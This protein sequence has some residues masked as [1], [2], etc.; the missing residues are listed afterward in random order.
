[1]SVIMHLRGQG[2]D[3]ILKLSFLKKKNLKLS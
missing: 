3:T 1:M 2:E